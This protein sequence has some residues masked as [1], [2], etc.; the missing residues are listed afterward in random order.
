MRQQQEQQIMADGPRCKRRKQAN[1]R[2][3][4]VF[5]FPSRIREMARSPH[6][7]PE[8]TLGSAC[9]Y[10]KLQVRVCSPSDL[11]TALHLSFRHRGGAA[12]DCFFYLCN[13]LPQHL[14][15]GCKLAITES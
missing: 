10:S 11:Q 4:N 2:R 8:S 6:S 7:Q 13:F 9:G 5:L 12:A 15:I 3:K 14:A 1:P